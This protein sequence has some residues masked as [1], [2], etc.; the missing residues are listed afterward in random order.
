MPTD[1][2]KYL[3]YT[4]ALAERVCELMI[5]GKSLREI[6][7]APGMPA[8]RNIFYWLRDHAEF[9]ERY[10]VAR[11]LQAEW[12]SHEILAIADDSSGD[13]T[14]NE[15]GERVVDHENINRSRLRCDSRKWLL[16]K[17]LP[18]RYGDRVT[19]DVTVRGG[20][21]E[22]TT[23]ELLAIA[24]SAGEADGADGTVH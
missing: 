5:E 19:A 22:L 7:E 2:R 11:M 17:L 15:H 21:K 3:A 24:G 18:Q 13:I 6:C 4:P 12:W 20:V 10:D 1:R 16:S 9:R 14:I 23:E 8:R